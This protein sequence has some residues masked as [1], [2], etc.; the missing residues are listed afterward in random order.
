MTK[1]SVTR[2]KQLNDLVTSVQQGRLRSQV[3]VES[4]LEVVRAFV[5]SEVASDIDVVLSAP[6]TGTDHSKQKVQA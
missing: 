6:T 1:D 4:M 3:L 2:Y 5:P